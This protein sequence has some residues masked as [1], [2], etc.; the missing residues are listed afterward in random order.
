MENDVMHVL[1]V[2][3]LLNDAEVLAARKSGDRYCRATFRESTVGFNPTFFAVFA[4]HG[5]EV[6]ETLRL[7]KRGNAFSVGGVI[8]VHVFEDKRGAKPG[9][10]IIASSLTPL[11]GSAV[12]PA[13]RQAATSP[14]KALIDQLK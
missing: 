3:S 4:H 7:A 9:I 5:S 2:G 6:F 8:Q 1:A 12:P 11:K 14:M 10:D 13:P